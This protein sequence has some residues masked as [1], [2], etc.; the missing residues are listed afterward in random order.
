MMGANEREQS[1][2]AELTQTP[3]QAERARTIYEK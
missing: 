1:T 2:R 3:M